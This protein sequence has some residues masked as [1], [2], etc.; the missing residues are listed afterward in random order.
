MVTNQARPA[1][2]RQEDSCRRLESDRTGRFTER[3]NQ[4]RYKVLYN[5]T[6]PRVLQ[7]CNMRA[8]P[9]WR[10]HAQVTP[11]ESRYLLTALEPE[12]R[13]TAT[14][15]GSVL[16]DNVQL[17]MPISSLDDCEW[18]CAGCHVEFFVCDYFNSLTIQYDAALNRRFEASALVGRSPRESYIGSFKQSTKLL[19]QS[20]D[21]T[22]CRT[23]H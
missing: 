5:I 16:L 2:S 21:C 22:T 23:V 8:A 1:P 4:S 12:R 18:T 15:T 11:C 9:R 7:F 19:N 17:Y 3:T 20:L 6:R 10:S 14:A 13:E